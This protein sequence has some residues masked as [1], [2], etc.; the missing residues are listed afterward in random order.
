M[1]RQWAAI[2][3]MSIGTL[4]EKS[5]HA[6]LK[7]WVA[8]PGDQFEVAVDGFVADVVRGELLLEIQ[9]RHL[10]AMKHKLAR[11]L[12]KHAVQIL[13]PIAQE[14]WIVRETAVGDPISRRRSP[15]RGQ[16]GDIFRE[17]VRL[18]DWLLHPNLSIILLLTQEEEIWRDDGQGSWRRKHWSLYDR[19][20]LAVVNQISLAEKTDFLA[21][22]P[23]NL[24]DPFTN[25][26]LA[27]TLPCRPALAQKITYTLRHIQALSVA[28][29]EGHS[30]LYTTRF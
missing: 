1:R 24:P 25:R 14:K 6:A 22:L 23:A 21:L 26:Q 11:L 27:D 12:P 4:G 19:R 8:Q 15:K 16:P 13:H 28:G 3:F 2:K 29:K 9:T 30:N 7:E 17:L 18:T 5:L 10:Y 20:L